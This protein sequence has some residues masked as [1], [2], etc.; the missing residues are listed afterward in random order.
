MATVGEVT[1]RYGNFLIP[2]LAPRDGVCAICKRDIRPGWSGCYQCSVQRGALSQ[3][4][5]AVAPIALSVKGEQW[6][7]ELSSYKNSPN[8]SVRASLAVR[9]GAVLWRWLDAHEPCV[10][11]CARVKEFPLVVPVP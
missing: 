4:A 8:P 2:V 1:A 7:Y 6:A 11:Q 10:M 9:L 5:D 3:T